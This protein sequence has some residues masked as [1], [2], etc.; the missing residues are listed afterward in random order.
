MLFLA[1]FFAF[2]Q[3]E[4]AN[5]MHP[6]EMYDL[7]LLLKEWHPDWSEEQLAQRVELLDSSRGDKKSQFLIPPFEEEVWKKNLREIACGVACESR[8]P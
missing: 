3:N 7:T 4:G 1:F 6:H 5:V 2:S 8:P